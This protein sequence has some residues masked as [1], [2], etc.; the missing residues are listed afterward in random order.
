MNIVKKLLSIV[1]VAALLSTSVF[2]KN[3]LGIRPGEALKTPAIKAKVES[4]LG[5]KIETRSEMKTALEQVKDL[6]ENYQAEFQDTLVQVKDAQRANVEFM[7]TTAKGLPANS[8]NFIESVLKRGIDGA[9]AKV[10][11]FAEAS[12]KFAAKFNRDV[13]QKKAAECGATFDAPAA[14]NT[15]QYLTAKAIAGLQAKTYTNA[16]K[17]MNEAGVEFFRGLGDKNPV[18]SEEYVRTQCRI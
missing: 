18:K 14:M 1:A 11:K 10:Q 8:R 6:S 17:K 16:L 3:T 2:A 12:S 15:V 9:K 7:K 13:A 5:R 4:L